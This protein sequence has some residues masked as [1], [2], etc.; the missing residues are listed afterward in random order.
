MKLQL[1]VYSKWGFCAL[2]LLSLVSLT[3]LVENESRKKAQ[4]GLCNSDFFSSKIILS[5]AQRVPQL[6]STD[7]PKHK[8]EDETS[9]NRNHIITSTR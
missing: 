3:L 6:N 2:S 1:Y 5:K 4:Q 9:L 7:H 8:E